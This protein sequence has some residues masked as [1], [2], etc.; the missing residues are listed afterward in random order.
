MPRRCHASVPSPPGRF[1]S[2]SEHKQPRCAVLGLY[3]SLRSK[4]PCSGIRRFAIIKSGASTPLSSILPSFW[5]Y[6]NTSPGELQGLS[7]SFFQKRGNLPRL[8]PANQVKKTNLPFIP[9]VA[10]ENWAHTRAWMEPPYHVA[11]E[12]SQFTFVFRRGKYVISRPRGAR[13]RKK[14]WDI[15]KSGRIQR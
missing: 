4:F 7:Q 15:E 3:S 14:N 1:P 11:I 5:L 6:Y 9:G 8:F 13:N 2:V 12:H 10:A